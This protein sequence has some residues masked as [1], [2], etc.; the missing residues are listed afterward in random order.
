MGTNLRDIV[1]LKDFRIKFLKGLS[2]FG[3]F[4]LI[5]ANGYAQPSV[6]ITS[7][8]SSPTNTSPIA[9]TITFSENVIGFILNKTAPEGAALYLTSED[10]INVHQLHCS[11]Y[12]YKACVV[13]CAPTYMKL[14]NL[15]SLPSHPDHHYMDHLHQ[16]HHFH[17][18]LNIHY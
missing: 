9:V 4:L 2:F 1:I 8:E 7:T 16:Q 17:R 10:V 18:D 3:L 6:V 14:A 15:E 13:F 12:S 11:T 5:V